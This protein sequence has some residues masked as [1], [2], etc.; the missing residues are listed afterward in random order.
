MQ[1]MKSVSTSEVVIKGKAPSH[2]VPSYM[3]SMEIPVVY[4]DASNCKG[5]RFQLR[6]KATS[7]DGKITTDANGLHVADA[8]EV[9]LFLSAATSFN[10]FDKC[11]DKEGKDENRI[12]ANYLTAASAKSFDELK[13]KSHRGLSA[14][15]QSR[16]LS[17]SVPILL[18]LFRW[19]SD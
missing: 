1:C 9:I 5:M 8:T 3:S 15:F 17:N 19:T 7:Q 18:T 2:T 12:A 16:H 14:L 6:L 13:K 11:P 4:N 10:G